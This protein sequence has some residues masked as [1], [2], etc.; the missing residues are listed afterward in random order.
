MLPVEESFKSVL[1]SST[2]SLPEADMHH[3]E[4]ASSPRYNHVGSLLQSLPKKDSACDEYCCD[5]KPEQQYSND[6]N[7]RRRDSSEDKQ[8]ITH[9]RNNCNKNR[10]QI[11]Q[12]GTTPSKRGEGVQKE[13]HRKQKQEREGYHRNT[14]DGRRV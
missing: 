8:S 10:T 3:V 4:A 9:S 12:E 2:H 13:K 7:E 11:N 14:N 6:K 5:E 1:P